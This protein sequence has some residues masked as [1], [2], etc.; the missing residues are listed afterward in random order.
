VSGKRGG[1]EDGGWKSSQS[2]GSK[3][4]GKERRETSDEG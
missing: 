3:Y 1:G 2:T 4:L